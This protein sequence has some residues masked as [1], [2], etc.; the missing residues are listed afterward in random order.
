[1]SGPK[2]NY[3]EKCHLFLFFSRILFRSFYCWFSIISLET[4]LDYKNSPCRFF[5]LRLRVLYLTEHYFLCVKGSPLEYRSI[6]AKIDREN[7]EVALSSYFFLLLNW[8]AVVPNGK[9]PDKLLY[10][11]S[12]LFNKF[13]S[14]S[15]HFTENHWFDN[16]VWTNSLFL[17]R[18]AKNSLIQLRIIWNS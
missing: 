1:M 15:I 10:R 17:D 2:L 5:F 14:K 9:F 18:Q 6:I 12:C 8:Y 4:A 7:S 16:D 13:N 11:S 3:V